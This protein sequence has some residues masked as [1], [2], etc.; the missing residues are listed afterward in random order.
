[1]GLDIFSA[2]EKEYHFS[3]HGIHEIRYMAYRSIG[4]SLSFADWH[5]QQSEG[6]EEYDKTLDKFPNLCW[7][8]DCDGSYTLTDEVEPFDKLTNLSTGNSKGLLE[9]L[10]FVKDN[11]PRNDSFVSGREWHIFD[12]LY[13]LVKDVVNNY[14]G[15]IEF[16]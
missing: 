3:Y 15:E 1:M 7:H 2:S 4:G 16:H 9:E 11:V 10:Q 12:A 13:D 8:S 6:G 5:H 14:D